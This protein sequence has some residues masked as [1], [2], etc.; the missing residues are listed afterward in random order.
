MGKLHLKKKMILSFLTAII[1]PVLILSIISLRS[2]SNV[3][4]NNMEL[5]SVQT[6]KESQKGLNIYLKSLS[7]QTN[8]LAR[9]N[10]LKLLSADYDKN[11]SA[12][13]DSLT[14][15][16][17]VCDGAAVRAYYVTKEQNYVCS[18]L[19]YND[20][21]KID[22][23]ISTDKNVNLSDKDWY[24]KAL[25]NKKRDGVFSGYSEPYKDNDSGKTI[26]TVAQMVKQNDVF[27]G[28]VAIDIDFE[29]I[30]SFVKNIK[31][32]NTGYSVLV[33]PEGTVLVNNPKNTYGKDTLTGASF[34]NDVKSKK[35]STM[36]I[37]NG[38]DISQVTS[39]TDTITGWKLVGVITDDEIAGNMKSITM[40][41]AI[42]SVISVIIG[43]L[44]AVYVTRCLVKQINK[45][46]IAVRNVASGD[47]TNK[48]KIDVS[49]E[50][51]ELGNN[52]NLMTDNVS[53][54]IKNLQNTSYEILDA[55]ENIKNMSLETKEAS[56]NVAA[57]I[58]QVAEGATSQAE[59]TDEATSEV[60]ILSNQLDETK[61]YIDD[62]N[63]MSR[64][65]KELSNSG[66]NVLSELIKKADKSTKN[67]VLS[68]NILQEVIKSI[69]NINFI[70]D[71]IVEITEQTTLLSLNAGIEAARAGEAGK[72]FAVVADEIRKLS[73]ESRTS[74]D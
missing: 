59:S 57:A 41:I 28:V 71:A 16:V 21:G 22:G 60:N 30:E 15:A 44:I 46:N 20:K 29:N 17:K 26:L 37:K 63:D 12:A 65:T 38:I 56:D 7:Q 39:L 54:L 23:K 6:L 62:I 55:A 43:V 50:F 48:I 52:F 4:R 40:T 53:S 35:Q 51:G 73:E 67:S 31:I 61:S 27:V 2:F 25:E 11:I 1:L 32:L 74:T 5:A 14:A 47:F 49:D 36:T 3:L 24:K 10:E 18:T 69:Q 13:E 68:Q 8:L 70:S 19:A 34:W 33:N 72:G 58:G 9:K 66:I 42:L 64:K 45:L